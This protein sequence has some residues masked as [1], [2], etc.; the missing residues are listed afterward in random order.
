MRQIAREALRHG[1]PV[2]RGAAGADDPEAQGVEELHTAPGE[3][4]ERRVEDLAQ[5]WG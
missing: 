4:Q 1:E 5:G 2:G 3:E